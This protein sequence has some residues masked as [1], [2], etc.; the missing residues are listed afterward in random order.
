MSHY[1]IQNAKYVQRADYPAGGKYRKVIGPPPHGA[2]MGAPKNACTSPEGKKLGCSWIEHGGYCRS[3]YGSVASQIPYGKTAVYVPEYTKGNSIC[4]GLNERK[5]RKISAC[6]YIKEKRSGREYC[7]GIV[8]STEPFSSLKRFSPEEKETWYSN[9]IDNTLR[10]HCRCLLESA[11]GSLY[12]TGE[13]SINP[14]AICG[15]RI[16]ESHAKQK[17]DIGKIASKDAVAIRHAACTKYAQF[18]KMPTEM[19]YTYAKM[20]QKTGT[21]APFFGN[22]PKFEEFIKNSEYYRKSILSAITAFSRKEL[23]PT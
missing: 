5:C 13:I 9:K 10:K 3:P 11:A 19:L 12:R 7:R 2:C 17:S 6:R 20:R 4:Q 1:K 21:G 16:P 8:R 18:E 23:S 14:Y 15:A 22:L